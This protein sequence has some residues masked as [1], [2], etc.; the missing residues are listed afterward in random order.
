MGG[1]GKARKGNSRV[2][3]K[4]GWLWKMRV[5]ENDVKGGYF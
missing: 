5:L 2:E 4:G 1:K 3:R